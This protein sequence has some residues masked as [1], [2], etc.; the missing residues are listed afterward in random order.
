V[1]LAK[2]GGK[3]PAAI[4]RELGLRAGVVGALFSRLREAGMPATPANRRRPPT[5][6]SWW[7]SARREHA[8]DRA[9]AGV[10][11][12]TIARELGTTRNAVIGFLDRVRRRGE[13]PRVALTRQELVELDK[14]P[15]PPTLEERLPPMPKGCRYIFELP[16]YP[17]LGGA[18]WY[19][20]MR[21][22]ARARSIARN[23]A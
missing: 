15:D 9:A 5:V 11:R 23:T 21:R 18:R 6:G 16:G 17:V 14:L 2:E 19:C 10:A 4:G 3:G 1:Q 12:E 13:D 20:A 22:L 8:L 7:T